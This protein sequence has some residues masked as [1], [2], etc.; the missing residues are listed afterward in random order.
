MCGI[1]LTEIHNFDSIHL[2]AQK[3]FAPN[4]ALIG[5]VPGSVAAAAE[6][7]EGCGGKILGDSRYGPNP[8]VYQKLLFT[9]QETE[10]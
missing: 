4:T 5:V 1:S 7:R 3:P 6:Y 8:L 9:L 2:L 10:G